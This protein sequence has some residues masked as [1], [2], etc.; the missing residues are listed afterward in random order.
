MPPLMLD[1]IHQD[2]EALERTLAQNEPAVQHLVHQVRERG[3]QRII[4]SGM[5]SSDTAAQMALPVYLNHCP[6]PTWVLMSPDPINYYAPLVD[7]RALVIAISRSGE[8][9]A[10][11]EVLR[12]ANQRGALC[13]ALTGTP[14]SLLAQE[15]QVR[16]VT[17]EGLEKSFPKT[18][19]AL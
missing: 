14:D 5:G 10:V 13:V 2:A 3:I 6:L 17:Q 16:L 9:G 11:L 19:S 15:A 4:L 8:R 7:D 12:Q 18:L 1:Y